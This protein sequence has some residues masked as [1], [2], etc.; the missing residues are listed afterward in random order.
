MVAGDIDK[1][2]LKKF[3]NRYSINLVPDNNSQFEYNKENNYHNN[4]N[5]PR[6][7]IREDETS[8]VVIIY[9]TSTTAHHSQDDLK[10]KLLSCHLGHGMSS[11]LLKK[12]REEKGLSYDV[13]IYNPIREY[14]SPFVIHASTTK[15]KA[16]QT[17]KIINQSINELLST[18]LTIDE[19]R[20]AKA[21]LK[22]NF[23]Y[24]SQTIGQRIERKAM[25]LGYR[26]NISHD[27]E[28]LARINEITSSDIQITANR[29]LKKPKLSLCGPPDSVYKIAEDNGFK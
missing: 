27:N 2:Q 4:R 6:V 1:K 9:G 22:G 20:L 3:I 24:N 18:P 8:Q 28:C 12:I 5:S 17:L 10:I 21:K 16:S 23:A 7:I 15:E 26:M 14:N 11:I 13:G 29:F 25:L 19:L